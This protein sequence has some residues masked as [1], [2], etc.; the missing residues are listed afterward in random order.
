[1]KVATVRFQAVLTVAAAEQLD[2]V[3][4]Q[5]ES[6]S[7]GEVARRAIQLLD[8]VVT[9]RLDHPD[10]VQELPRGRKTRS[11]ILLSN[12]SDERLTRLSG[13]L[14]MSRSQ[15]FYVALQ[16][17]CAVATAQIRGETFEADSPSGLVIVNQFLIP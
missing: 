12:L 9:M 1:M 11:Q 14:A 13:A 2:E 6:I 8:S 4:R 7:Y 17:Y 16:W 10:I 5:T 3:R 15:T